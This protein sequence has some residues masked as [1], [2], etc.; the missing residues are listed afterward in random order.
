MPL[1]FI[2]RS[3][4]RSSLSFASRLF[5][6]ARVSHPWMVLASAQRCRPSGVLG[7]VDAPPCVL[8]TFLPRMEALRHCRPLRFDFA[9][10]REA[11]KELKIFM[12]SSIFAT[13]HSI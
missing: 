2:V 4:S 13:L 7:P 5:R 10:Q 9:W 12:V 6:I 1:C 11:S 3:K 8:H